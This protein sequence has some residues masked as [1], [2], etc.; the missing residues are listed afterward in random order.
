MVVEEIAA[1]VDNLK[2]VVMVVKVEAEP[3]TVVVMIEAATLALDDNEVVMIL[4]GVDCPIVALVVVSIRDGPCLNE[5][6]VA[7]G[8]AHVF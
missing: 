2:G 8:C 4:D 7:G 5:G 3:E 6:V 1:G